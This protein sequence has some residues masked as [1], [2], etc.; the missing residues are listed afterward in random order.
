VTELPTRAFAAFEIPEGARREI[1][2]FCDA[3]RRAPEAAGLR[4]VRTETLH[5]TV[6]F[7]GDLDRK[8]VGKAERA[9]QS[10]DRAWS[11]PELTLGRLGAFP[12][13][14]RAQVLWLGIEDPQGGLAALAAEV[15]LAIR[16]VGFGPADKPFVGH[17][18]LART[19]R[20][21][22]AKDLTAW[23]PRLTPPRGPL[24]ITAIT[25]FRSDL[26]PQGPLYTP[27]ASAHPRSDAAASDAAAPDAA[28]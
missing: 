9:I 20:G 8:A 7:F 15:D 16:K 12:S 11:P 4:W 14:R 3:E 5:M 18:T 13:L 27:L 26:R 28:G 2:S 17:L 10:F 24:T 1:G 6:R 23:A 22:D 25:L 21:A 19:G